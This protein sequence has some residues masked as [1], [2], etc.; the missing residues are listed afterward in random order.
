[1][2]AKVREEAAKALTHAVLSW[3]DDQTLQPRAHLQGFEV[4]SRGSA[5]TRIDGEPELPD[6]VFDF[7]GMF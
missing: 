5:R 3:R 6:F 1:M 4:L 7:R 2:Q